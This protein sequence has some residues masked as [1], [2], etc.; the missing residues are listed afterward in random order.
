MLE[1]NEITSTQNSKIKGVVA[2]LE[3]SKL[4]R[5]NG[6]FV[7]EGVRELSH[8]LKAGYSVKDIY[9]LPDILSFSQVEKILSSQKNRCNSS[10]SKKESLGGKKEPQIYSV[11]KDVYAKM[12]Y[13]EGTE[14]VIAV[15]EVKNLSLKDIVFK[16]AE[17]NANPFILIVEKVEK[18][19]NLGALLR[20]ADAC[21]VDAV[22]VCDPLTDLYNPN[23]IRSSLGGIF[24]QQVVACSNQEAYKWLKENNIAIFTAQLQDSEWYYNRDLIQPC[25]IV[26][27]NEANGLTD[28]WREVSNAK[29]KIPMLGELD[30]LNVSVSA[31]VL[32]YEVVRQ[33]ECAK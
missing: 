29:V 30:S 26:M 25:A 8:C 32:C 28:F 12:A 6:L 17:A 7:V 33:R 24:T 10:G 20:T 21:G 3:K 18:P 9:F 27:G 15:I 22:I 23:L 5:S 13:R 19:G 1:V 4:R 31:A 11:S 14:G 2:L 16:S